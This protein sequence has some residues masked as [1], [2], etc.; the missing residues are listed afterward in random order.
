MK[1]CS[2]FADLLS[3]S[4]SGTGMYL[5]HLLIAL[6]FGDVD[7]P[8]WTRYIDKAGIEERAVSSGME[9]DCRS[10]CHVKL[11]D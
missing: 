6:N 2:N 11:G 1:C 4:T 8:A 5:L 7:F 9:I 10:E 3:Q